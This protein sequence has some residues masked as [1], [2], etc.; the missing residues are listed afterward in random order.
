M[1]VGW[2]ATGMA[3]SASK[4][5]QYTGLALYSFAEACIFLPLVLIALS[6]AGDGSLLL[7]ASL[8]TALLFL[9]LTATVFITRADFSFLRTALTV[10]GFVALGLILCSILFGFTLGL[11]FSGAMVVFAAAA[12]L[13]TTSKSCMS[14][15]RNNTWVP[16]SS[17]LHPWCCSSGM[18]CAF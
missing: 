15:R 9:G 7:Q 17:C 14:I 11:V 6:V 3:H 5:M 13:Y 4:Q 10:G 12:I 2:L 1:V 18:C 8:M 16:R